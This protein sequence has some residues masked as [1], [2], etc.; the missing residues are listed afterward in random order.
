VDQAYQDVLRAR[1]SW[2]AAQQNYAARLDSF[3]IDMGL[4]TDARIELDRSELEQLAITAKAALGDKFSTRLKEQQKI[5][6]SDAPVEIVPISREGGGPLEIESFEAIGIA[7]KHRMDLLILQGRVYDAQRGVTVA[8]NALKADLTLFGTGEAGERRGIGSAD[9]PDA[10]LRLDKGRYSAGLFLDLPWE[11]TAEQ[12]AY[13]NSYIIL[14][15]SIRNVQE[16]EDQ[17][18]FQIFNELRNLLETRENYMIQTQGVELARERVKSSELFL[19]A[20]RAQIRDLLEAQQALVSTQ[21]ALTEALVNYRISELE[22][23][24]D[25]GVLEVDHKGVWS[26]YRP[27]KTE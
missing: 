17:I 19:Q 25:M 23:Q 14:Q 2:I 12:D 15:R 22:L 4:P 10:E 7:L 16:K 9:L 20:G 1:V 8:A 26:E 21:N 3:K 11:R 6:A 18:K 5:L 13:R 27:G 24:R